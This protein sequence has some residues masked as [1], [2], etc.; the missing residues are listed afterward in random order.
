MPKVTAKVLKS[1]QN[2]E[3][4]HKLALIRFNDS[5][6]PKDETVTVKWGSVRSSCQNSLY[7]VYLSWLID[8]G[9]L[10]EHGHFDP[11][12]LHRDLKTHF[13]AKKEMTKDGF[14]AIEE[15]TTTD[16]TKSE[17][18]DY[19]EKVRAFV[20]DWFEIDDSVFWSEYQE[21]YGTY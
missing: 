17:F 4:G 16:L 10:K 3:T 7:W 9:G 2:K 8:E 13:L 20:K 18:S 19:V 12:A 1:G 15:A 21:T 14:K 6:P 5:F 11:E